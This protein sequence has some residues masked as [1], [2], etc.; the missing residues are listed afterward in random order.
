MV[1]IL[2]IKAEL[3]WLTITIPPRCKRWK[4]PQE[5]TD[6]F[7]DAVPAKEESILEPPAQLEHSNWFGRFR[8]HRNEGP[9]STMNL[10]ALRIV[11]DA[12]AE[13]S[14]SASNLLV[15]HLRSLPCVAGF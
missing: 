15:E 12:T 8:E 14:Q 2:G 9:G 7:I 6:K 10:T 13:L 5:I 1:H 11:Q 4:M 3:G